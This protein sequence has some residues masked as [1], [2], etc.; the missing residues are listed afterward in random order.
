MSKRS[1]SNNSVGDEH[2]GK[3]VFCKQHCYVHSTGW[4]TV[5]LDQKIPLKSETKK[6]AIKEAQDLGLS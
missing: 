1:M 4:C 2:L 6:E 5:S 3:F